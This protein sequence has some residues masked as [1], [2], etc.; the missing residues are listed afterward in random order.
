YYAMQFIHGQPLDL[1]LADIRRLR[2]L[3]AAAPGPDAAPIPSARPHS[4]TVS[5]IAN[6]L[7]TGRFTAGGGTG[8]LAAGE[9]L[10][11]TAPLPPPPAG[12]GPPGGGAPPPPRGPPPPTEPPADGEPSALGTS[13]LGGSGEL[14]YFREVARVGAQVSD[15][16]EYAH[17]RGVLHRDIKP[18]NLL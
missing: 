16:L 14:R 6:G 15:A 4:P 1:V 8:T 3:T 10:S 12:D 17:R 18:S 2:D 11:A 13:S 7:L 5:G 9:D